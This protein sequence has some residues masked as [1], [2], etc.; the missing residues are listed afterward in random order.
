[1]ANI[2]LDQRNGMSSR[3]LKLNNNCL[4]NQAGNVSDLEDMSSLLVWMSRLAR[5]SCITTQ[6]QHSGGEHTVRVSTYNDRPHREACVLEPSLNCWKTPTAWAQTACHI[7]KEHLCIGGQSFGV[8]SRVPC[9]S[10]RVRL[11]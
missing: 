11:F 3:S 5:I 2:W 7:S 9:L 4:T 8:E 1:M 6:C 10:L